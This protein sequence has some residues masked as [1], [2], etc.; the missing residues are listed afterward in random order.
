MV[1]NFSNLIKRQKTKRVTYTFKVAPAV[2]SCACSILHAYTCFWLPSRIVALAAKVLFTSR[3]YRSGYNFYSYFVRKATGGSS[4]CA[5]NS[6]LIQR[7]KAGNGTQRAKP[8][9]HADG[10]T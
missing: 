1:V 3:A 9:E 7:C 6:K 4:M 10:H 2:L 5:G 8:R